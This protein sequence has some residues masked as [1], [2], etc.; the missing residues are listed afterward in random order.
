MTVV[1]VIGCQWGDEGKGKIVDLL[2]R[3]AAAVVRF[4]GGNN[5]GHTVW[6]DGQKSVFHLMPTGFLN[7]QVFAVIAN[8][9]V[10]NP[11]V[12][13][14]EIAQLQA[15]GITVKN[16][17]FISEEAHL[18]TGLHPIIDRTRE[19]SEMLAKGCKIGTTGLG[20]GPA[21][22]DKCARVG[23]RLLDFYNMEICEEKFYHNAGIHL[24]I[25]Q[26][27]YNNQTIPSLDELYSELKE[28][29]Q[30]LLPFATDT[31]TMLHEMSAKKLNILLEGAQ[32]TFLDLDHGTYPFVTS[33]NTTIGGAISG[34]GLSLK[35]IDRV[36][37][38]SKCYTTRV[39]EGPF[40]TELH[41]QAGQMLQNLGQEKGA[42]TG[43]ARR[44]G[45]LDIPQ[46]QKACQLNGFDQLVLTKLD[47]LDEFDKIKI[48][49]AYID[50]N[51][52]IKQAFPNSH[53]SSEAYQPQYEELAGWQ[54]S[55][56]GIT[57]W[58]ELPAA[59]QNFV[60]RIEQLLKL[61]VAIIST[62]AD[63][64]ATIMRQA[65]I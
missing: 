65:V 20:I 5:A 61:D 9:V 48:C 27:T 32:G 59:A 55:T 23:L 11:R 40:P 16:R 12:L 57:S 36:L 43:R 50:K 10:V 26:E 46:L 29:V 52:Q 35:Q 60:T 3:D 19:N 30:R 2:A 17:L 1:A 63:R 62:G 44:C 41:D 42:T 13:N 6:V 8:G 45:W 38:V 33:S 15:M 24:S 22:E 34:T 4:Q 56:K 18:I 21:Y 14:Q 28:N 54:T 7:P 47:V 39:G 51:S 53:E 49:T 58:T 64:K 31:T 25:L 37:G